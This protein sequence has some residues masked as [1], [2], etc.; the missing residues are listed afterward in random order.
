MA[1]RLRPALRKAASPSDGHGTDADEQCAPEQL[2]LVQDGFC[3]LENEG[4]GHGQRLVDEFLKGSMSSALA[5]STMGCKW[6]RLA[7]A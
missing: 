4:L 6:F 1:L 5:L 2:H 3:G 7:R